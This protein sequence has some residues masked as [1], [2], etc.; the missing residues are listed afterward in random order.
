MGRPATSKTSDV[1]EAMAALGMAGA[2][3]GAFVD[4]AP[5]VEPPTKAVEVPVSVAEGPTTFVSK[6][7]EYTV[8]VEALNRYAHF[9]GNSFTT[10]DEELIGALKGNPKYGVDFFSNK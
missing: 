7:K 5:V 2:P 9:T 4:T 1:N 3:V 10:S 6:F 8:Y